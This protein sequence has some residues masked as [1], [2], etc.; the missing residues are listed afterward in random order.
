MNSNFLT[1]FGLIL[2][3]AL[4]AS[5]PVENSEDDFGDQALMDH[6]E[7]DQI[8]QSGEEANSEEINPEDRGELQ[9]SPLNVI[10]VNFIFRFMSSN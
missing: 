7:Q 5:T 3:V 9:S 8:S 10:T 6:S 4:V 1:A 2:V